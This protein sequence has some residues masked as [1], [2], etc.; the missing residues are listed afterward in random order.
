MTNK[1]PAQKYPLSF[2]MEL[3]V[4]Q[5]GKCVLCGKMLFSPSSEVHPELG[6]VTQEHFWPK[7]HGGTQITLAHS[8]C[9]QKKGNRLP[10]SEEMKRYASMFKAAV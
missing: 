2:I 5:R 10:N 3:Y 1:S 6:P 4:K 8:K 7:S 9:N